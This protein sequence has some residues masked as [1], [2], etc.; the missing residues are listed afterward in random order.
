MGQYIF[1]GDIGGTKTTLTIIEVDQGPRVFLE[2]ETFKS[3]DY[4]SLLSIAND[5]LQKTKKQVSMASFGIAGPVLDGKVQATNLP[6]S[7][8]ESG[9]SNALKVPVKVINDLAATA[10][11]VPFLAVDELLSLNRGNKVEHGSVGVI[12]PGTG[13]GEA[14][15]IWGES[16]YRAF[17]SEGGHA[18]F[19][20]TD[21][22]QTRL[23]LY[24]QNIF[25]HVS[26]ERVCSGKGLVNIYDFLHSERIFAEPDWLREQIVRA[27]NPAP[28]ITKAALEQTAEIAAKTLELFLS[29]LGAEA[30]NMALKLMSTGGIYLGGGILPRIIP[31]LENGVF[32]ASF[33]AK[34][35]FQELLKEIPVYLIRNSEAALLGAACFGLE[36]WKQYGKNGL[37]S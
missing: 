11:A 30:G 1:A 12:A 8:T 4:A 2:K 36:E 26:Y 37:D 15:M 28:A 9:L 24:M 19:A 3:K 29:I 17:S 16:R 33:T 25:G 23:F 32:G 21:E 22:L 18:D 34:G 7:I 35:R 6:W 27:E 13:L 31:L 14:F 5:F 10:Y 20:P